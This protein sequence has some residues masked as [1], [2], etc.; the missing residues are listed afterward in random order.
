ML[1]GRFKAKPGAGRAVAAKDL[2]SS[3]R[4]IFNTLLAFIISQLIAAFVVELALGLHHPGQASASLFDQSIT[5]Q[6]FYVLIAEGLAAYLTIWLVRRRRMGLGVI[7]LGRRPVWNDVWRATGGFVVF[8]ALLIIA[9]VILGLLFPNFST[10]QTQNLGFNNINTGTQN[11]LA[12]LALVVLPPLGEEPLVRGY[13]YSGLRKH[14]SFKRAMLITSLLFGLAHLEFGS[15]GPLVW[16]AA[17]DTFILSVVLVYLRENTGALWAGMLVHFL[18]NIV[19][20]G[21]HFH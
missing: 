12:F 7:G 20:F 21:I 17:I 11:T 3:Y 8:Y 19:A 18:N 16:G 15:G 6:F 13:L 10:N 9:G 1:K 2:G 5:G 4:V 14:F